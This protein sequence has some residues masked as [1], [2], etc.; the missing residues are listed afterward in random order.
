MPP[1]ALDDAE[2]PGNQQRQL[3]KPD[4]GFGGKLQRLS[5]QG[6][7]DDERWKYDGGPLEAV[8]QALKPG[9]T[10]VDGVKVGDVSIVGHVRPQSCRKPMRNESHD[11]WR[12][13]NRLLMES[14]L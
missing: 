13:S 5:S 8:N 10:V 6:T 7:G 1:E 14:S 11:Q 9:Q 12:I 3:Q 2:S 4:L